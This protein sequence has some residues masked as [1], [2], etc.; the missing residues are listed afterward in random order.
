MLPRANLLAFQ[1]GVLGSLFVGGASV[2]AGEI[3]PAYAGACV[4]IFTI[5]L[6]MVLGAEVEAPQRAAVQMKEVAQ[7]E[8]KKQ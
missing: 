4:L 3:R 6:A 2:W 1:L 7:K 5:A 8:K